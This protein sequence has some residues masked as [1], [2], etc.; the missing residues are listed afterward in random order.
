M[1]ASF[2]VQVGA[3]MIKPSAL[4]D[5]PVMITHFIFSFVKCSNNFVLVA[6]V[7][8]LQLELYF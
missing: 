2:H 7:S 4:T 3:K 6:C 1:F 5:T 8:M